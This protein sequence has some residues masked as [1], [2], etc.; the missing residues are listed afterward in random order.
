MGD[1]TAKLTIEDIRQK[2][3]TLLGEHMGI[4]YTITGDGQNRI[5]IND[6]WASND[7]FVLSFEA[8]PFKRE[9]SHY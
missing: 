1:P 6:A 7:T 2:V 9:T 5:F 8:V 3:G 4:R